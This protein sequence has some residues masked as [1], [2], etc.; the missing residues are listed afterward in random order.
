M[1]HVVQGPEQPLLFGGDEQNEDR[2]PRPLRQRGERMRDRQHLRAARGVVRGSM[3]DLVAAGVGLADTEVVVVSR[4]H[5]H[6]AR[7]LRIAARQEPRHVRRLDTG[8]LVREC[9]GGTQT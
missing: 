3:V 2:A 9:D 4:E 7:E 5:D 6:F 8:H 1:Q